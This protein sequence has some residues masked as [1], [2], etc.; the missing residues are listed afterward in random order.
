MDSAR[1]G[2]VS[3]GKLTTVSQE[4]VEESKF[5]LVRRRGVDD[6][7]PQV[8][9]ICTGPWGIVIPGSY[10]ALVVTICLE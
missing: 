1:E 8:S 3:V 10:S 9:K 2:R 4:V 5:L 7:G 6:F